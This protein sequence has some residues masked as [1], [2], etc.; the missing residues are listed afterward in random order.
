MKK[1]KSL[2]FF[3]SMFVV[4]I[5]ILAS[6]C[7]F[8]I[9]S[10]IYV[11]SN[12]KSIKNLLHVQ[13]AAEASILDYKLISAGKTAVSVADM[14]ET[15]PVYDEKVIFE[16]ISKKLSHDPLLFGMGVWFEP[17]QYS[18]EKKYYGPY[19]YRDTNNKNIFTWA[20][21]TADYDYLGWDWY[22]V[23]FGAKHCSIY[24]SNLFYDQ[25]MNTYFLTGTAPIMKNQKIIG[26]A[27][28][29][30]SLREVAHYVNKIRVGYQ[31]YAFVLTDNGDIIGALP[32][33][34]RSDQTAAGAGENADTSKIFHINEVKNREYRTL[35]DT[36]IH[37]KD[38]G[39]L[40]L[41]G[42]REIASFANIG[43]TGLKLVLI[44]PQKELY[45][46]FYNS[47]QYYIILF[48]LSVVA[49]PLF[50]LFVIKKKIDQPLSKLLQKVN[51][52]IGGDFS[53]DHILDPVISAT[54]EFGIL[55]NSM[56]KL[57][58]SLD[59]LVT[60]L[61]AQNA[62]LTES[63]KKIELSEE[64]YRLIFEATNEGLWDLDL[65]TNIR[66]FSERWKEIFGSRLDVPGIERSDKMV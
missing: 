20:Y 39:L 63:R 18:K 12:K 44:Y 32:S 17:Y 24:F 49:I 19:M 50:V 5:T 52:I 66:V 16:K 30:I 41:D 45:S 8:L 2:R 14:I 58:D 59:E 37:A 36:V 57:S 46:S 48:V 3:L 35:L 40:E 54:N 23:V 15:M 31:G 11:Q 56:I 13:T 10:S 21:S 42:N 28:A 34:G 25:I 47:L 53:R 1:T 38:S 9:T 64:K 4:I 61:H 43:D 62:E 55:G 7:I 33:T 60:S 6:S 51:K 29:D 22:R 27:S 65:T 26:A